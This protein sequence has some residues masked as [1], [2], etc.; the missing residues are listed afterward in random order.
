[1]DFDPE[2]LPWMEDWIKRRIGE[3]EVRD[4]LAVTCPTT[5]LAGEVFRY[6][7]ESK[8]PYYELKKTGVEEKPGFTFFIDDKLVVLIRVCSN[9]YNMANIRFI[10][11]IFRII[12]RVPSMTNLSAV[13][14]VLGTV[15]ARTV[16]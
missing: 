1:M 7:I 5:I 6:D 4:W 13:H 10:S 16:T 3:T 8:L 15:A 2:R 14:S 9:H 12:S 11:N